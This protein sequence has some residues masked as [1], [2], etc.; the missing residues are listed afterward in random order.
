MMAFALNLIAALAAQPAIFAAA[1]SDDFRL[2]N[3]RAIELF[4]RDPRLMQ[5]ALAMFDADADGHLSILEA[6]KAAADFKSIAD[7]NRDG[8]VTPREYRA[9]VD[10]VVARWGTP[11][12]LRSQR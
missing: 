7:G 5:W 10:F 4:E 2:V 1:D 3:P 12:A 9:A 11:T 8:R 6:D